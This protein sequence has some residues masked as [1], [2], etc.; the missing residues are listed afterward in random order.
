MVSVPAATY[1]LNAAGTTTCPQGYSKIT[2]VSTCAAAAKFLGKPSGATATSSTAP[3][4]C[5][6]TAVGDVWLNTHPTGAANPNTQPLCHVTGAPPRSADSKSTVH[7]VR[8]R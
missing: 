6:L 7:S 1:A 4:G 2:D 3:T 8:K 5:I